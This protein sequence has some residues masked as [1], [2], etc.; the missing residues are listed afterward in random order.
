[1]YPS[2]LC[3]ITGRTS[4]TAAHQFPI[5]PYPTR[6]EYTI[7]SHTHSVYAYMCTV[8]PYGFLIEASNIFFF[9]L[10]LYNIIV[11]SV[12]VLKICFKNLFLVYSYTYTRLLVPVCPLTC[13]QYRPA[14]DI[15]HWY[16]AR[17]WEGMQ[18]VCGDGTVRKGRRA[19]ECAGVWCLYCSSKGINYPMNSERAI[20]IPWP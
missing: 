9:N 17:V 2:S 11:C 10:T 1:M 8:V 20:R 13:I 15:L 4:A 5:L 3:T 16:T 14:P 6:Y 12:S 7:S 18:W 19:I